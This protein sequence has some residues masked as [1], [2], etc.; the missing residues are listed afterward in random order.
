MDEED[1]SPATQTEGKHFRWTPH[2]DWMQTM[3]LLLCLFDFGFFNYYL[4]RFEIDKQNTIS[5]TLF[6]DAGYS[7]VLTITLYFRL[8]AVVLFLCRFK[9]KQHQAWQIAGYVGA[10]LAAI[11]W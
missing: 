2:P 4:F 9:K 11:G 1:G 5:E 7:I 8:L 10:S 6:T 3:V